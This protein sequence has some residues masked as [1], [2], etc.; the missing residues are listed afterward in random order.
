MDQAS[1]VQ[2][3][4]RG[5]IGRQVA[6]ANHLFPLIKLKGQMLNMVLAPGQSADGFSLA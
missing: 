6:L 3:T 2:A 1:T 5:E 4:R